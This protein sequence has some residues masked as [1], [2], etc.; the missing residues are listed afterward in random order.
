MNELE[1]MH[2]SEIIDMTNLFLTPRSL[3]EIWKDEEVSDIPENL[4]AH[5]IL[6]KS[7]K[8]VTVNL[9]F[10]FHWRKNKWLKKKKKVAVA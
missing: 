10:S 6:L 8:P 9:W 3:F 4:S 7:P 5:K 2:I 1:K